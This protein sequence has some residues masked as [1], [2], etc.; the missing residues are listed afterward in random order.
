[1]KIKPEVI[2]AVSPVPEFCFGWMDRQM[3]SNAI[4]VDQLLA[5]EATNKLK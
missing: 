2:F 4:V 5:A 1:M 3:M